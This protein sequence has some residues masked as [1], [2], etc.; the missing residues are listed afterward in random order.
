MEVRILK[1]LVV[2]RGKESTLRGKKNVTPREAPRQSRG[3]DQ[4]GAGRRGGRREI[5]Q[6]GG[7]RRGAAGM[8][9]Q[10]QIRILPYDYGSCQVK[11]G[12][13]SNGAVRR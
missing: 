11:V 4:V 7:L 3:P 13:H 10:H 9:A 8:V 5:T 12:Y 6:R 2:S 1:R